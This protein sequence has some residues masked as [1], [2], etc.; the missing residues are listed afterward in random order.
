[1]VTD[2]QEP[3]SDRSPTAENSTPDP[4]TLENCLAPESS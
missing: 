4:S 3:T 2:Q 1:M